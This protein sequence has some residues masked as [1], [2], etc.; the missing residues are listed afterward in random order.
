VRYQRRARYDG[1]WHIGNDK[2]RFGLQAPP[3]SHARRHYLYRHRELHIHRIFNSELASL[4]HL[5]RPLQSEHPE[6]LESFPHTP[7]DDALRLHPK[8]RQHPSFGKLY[9]HFGLDRYGAALRTPES[10]RHCI[11]GN[12]QYDDIPRQ[13]D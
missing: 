2:L 6:P 12:V 1:H 4:G 10:H 11:G 13:R 9:P 5:Q 8:L 7:N 3:K